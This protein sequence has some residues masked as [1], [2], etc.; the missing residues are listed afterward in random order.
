MVAPLEH[1][2][3]CCPIGDLNA[4]TSTLQ[5]FIS[6]ER[7]VLDMFHLNDEDTLKYFYNY[8]T[9]IAN[10]ISLERKS[11]STCRVNPYGH[12]LFDM[13]KKMNLFIA[14]SRKGNDN[15]VGRRTC[16]DASIV[17]YLNVS[18]D[19]FPLIKYFEVDEFNPILS[20]VHTK[21]CFNIYTEQIIREQ[22]IETS[23]RQT[24][25]WCS[26]K[27]DKFVDYV[28]DNQS[29][30]LKEIGNVLDNLLIAENVDQAD[31]D[32]VTSN[33]CKIFNDS[34]KIIFRTKRVGFFHK[35]Q[36]KRLWFTDICKNKRNYFIKQNKDT[37]FQKI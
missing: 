16:N 12:R 8:D 20:D 36:N 5:D 7:F 24:V 4:K 31:L 13:C 10:G 18:S 17:D 19:L 34:S 3:K 37:N 35:K 30:Q 2:T 9:V 21:I 29:D 28:K 27:G 22:N 26:S 6:P 33:I 23:Q 14:N 15:N 1:N 32:D 11:E 25:K